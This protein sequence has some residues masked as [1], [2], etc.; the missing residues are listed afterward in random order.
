MGFSAWNFVKGGS[1]ARERVPFGQFRADSA[2]LPDGHDRI[3]Q[4]GS[5]SFLHLLDSHYLWGKDSSPGLSRALRS[6]AVG[7]G[8]AEKEID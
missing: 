3:R 1:S 8:M 7:D 4:E 6:S 2:S 5:R